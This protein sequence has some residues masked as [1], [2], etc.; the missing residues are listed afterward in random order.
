MADLA[1]K[2]QELI[3]VQLKESL[4]KV[5]KSENN[6]ASLA[7]GVHNRECL[8]CGGDVSE[9]RLKA[10]PNAQMCIHCQAENE[11]SIY[12]RRKLL[13]KIRRGKK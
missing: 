7:L 1:D 4:S 12:R 11:T 3:E 8:E 6:R 5:G 9:E 10:L 13:S 2:A